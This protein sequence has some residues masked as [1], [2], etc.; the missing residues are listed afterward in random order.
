MDELKGVIINVSNP[1]LFE[2]GILVEIG[3][4]CIKYKESW[5]GFKILFEICVWNE[6]KLPVCMLIH[7]LARTLDNLG[8]T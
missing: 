8:Q 7:F 2:K 4:L 1:D 6:F 5:K 3:K